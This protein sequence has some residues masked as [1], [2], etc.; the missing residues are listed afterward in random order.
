LGL[1]YLVRIQ[2]ANG[3]WSL[4]ANGAER[5]ERAPKIV[6]DT[7]ATGLALLS[8]LGAGYDHYD[9]KYQQEVA[10]GLKALVSSQ[11]SN[12]DLYL[13]QE[14]SANQGIWLYSHGIAAIALCEAFGM[15]GDQSLRKPAQKALDFIVAAQHPQYGGWRYTPGQMSD[16]SVSGWQLM[17]LRSG[18]L[19]G[20]DVAPD[21]IRGVRRLLDSAATADASKY[22]YNPWSRDQSQAT[23]DRSPNTVMTAAGLLMRLYSGSTR[24]DASIQRGASLLA[25]RLPSMERPQ[26]RRSMSNPNRDAYYW[27]NA[28]QVMFHMQGELWQQWRDGLYPL[29]TKTQ[30]TSGPLAGSWRPFQP[31]PDRWAHHAGRVYLTTMN[32]LSL[33]VYY[34]HLP[35]YE[36]GLALQE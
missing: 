13:R 22:A 27:Y 4:Q 3:R 32:L 26:A 8:F 14:G 10:A 15:T 25:R 34:R 9:G 2:L 23:I 24:H 36:Q 6:S 18:Q 5:A 29:L 12:G 11:Q 33:E 35:L 19:A 28:T 21:A 16:L 7:A 20:L 1:E 31:A 30:E 17:A